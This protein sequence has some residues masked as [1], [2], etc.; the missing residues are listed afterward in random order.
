[1]GPTFQL[2]FLFHV[3]DLFTEGAAL[4]TLENGD[5][6]KE[7]DHQWKGTTCTSQSKPGGDRLRETPG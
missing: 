3:T 2:Q 4:Q 5:L 1:M 6:G 7:Q